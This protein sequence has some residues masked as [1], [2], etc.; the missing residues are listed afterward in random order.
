MLKLQPQWLKK[1]INCGPEFDFTRSVLAEFGINTVC[2]SAK[3]PNIFD[4]FSGKTAT[5][6]ILGDVCTRGCAFCCVHKGNPAEP[7]KDEPGRIA[8]AAA[9]LGLRHVVI[10]SVTRDDLPDGGSGQFVRAI[11]ALRGRSGKGTEIE[12]LVPDFRG[13]EPDIRRVIEASPDIFSHNIET[14]PR[15][16]GEI[17]AGADYRRSINVLKAAKEPNPAVTT[18]SGI[19][20]GL[21]ETQDEAIASMVDLRAA[22]CDMLSIGQYLRPTAGQIEIKRIVGPDEFSEL[23]QIGLKMGFKKVQSGPFVRSSYKDTMN[24]SS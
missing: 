5:F 8:E 19:M 13:N 23:K 10:T 11:S 1:K 15:L 2:Q 3:C 20:L 21:G 9:M 12:V 6:L 16:Y 7:D 14:V 4:C 17:R 22:G 18:K 24:M